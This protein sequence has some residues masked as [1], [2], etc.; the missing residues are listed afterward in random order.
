MQCKS[1]PRIRKRWSVT[2]GGSKTDSSIAD[3]EAVRE[4][5]E[6]TLIAGELKE[7]PVVVDDFHSYFDV[8]MD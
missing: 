3:C 6:G 7:N 5:E 4:V 2:N 1:L 8:L